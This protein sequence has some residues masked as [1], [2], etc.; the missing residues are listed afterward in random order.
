MLNT[1]YLPVSKVHQSK[2]LRFCLLFVVEVVS[3]R[4]AACICAP[5]SGL[6]LLGCRLGGDYDKLRGLCYH[7]V[8]IILPSCY[9]HVHLRPDLRDHWS[10]A[11]PC[12]PSHNTAVV[13]RGCTFITWY[14]FYLVG[15]DLLWLGTGQSWTTAMIDNNT[16]FN[17]AY[18]MVWLWT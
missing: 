2:H 11:R 18:W 14:G 17:F 16:I 13:K 10:W 1:W 4:A 3:R 7:H 9:H 15:F 12:S 6:H 5:G 8:T